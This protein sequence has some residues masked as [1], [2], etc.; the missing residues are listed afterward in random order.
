[1]GFYFCKR[2][3]YSLFSGSYNSRM[4]Q[5]NAQYQKVIETCQDIF[6]R[7]TTDYGTSWRIFRLSSVIDQ[8]YIKANRIRTIEEKGNMKIDDSIDSEFIGIINYCIIALIQMEINEENSIDMAADQ[9]FNLYDFHFKKALDLM[10]NKNHDYG[11]AWRMM[12]VS[13]FTDMLLVRIHRIRQIME[14]KGKTQ[15]SEGIESNLY[16]MIN[17]SAFALIKS[18]INYK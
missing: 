10:Q 5:T 12:Q 2:T 3:D 11:E 15:I 8:I 7:K 1:M 17:Y 16:D 18:D 9:V 4:N 14:N 13:T 6:K